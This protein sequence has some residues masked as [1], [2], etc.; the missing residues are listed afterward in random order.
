MKSSIL[1]YILAIAIGLCLTMCA[2]A[3]FDVLFV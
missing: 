2:L 3:W 1:D